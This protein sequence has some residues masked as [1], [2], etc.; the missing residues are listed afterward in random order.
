VIVNQLSRDASTQ[1][2]S[3]A[4]YGAARTE[5]TPAANA[6]GTL[7]L[8]TSTIAITIAVISYRRMERKRGGSAPSPVA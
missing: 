1:T 7:M 6:I 8:V 3:M 4:I 5:P 2:V